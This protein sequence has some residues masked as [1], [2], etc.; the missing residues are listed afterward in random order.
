M[1]TC[2]TIVLLAVTP[3]PAALI[4]I[5]VDPATA[6]PAAVSVSVADPLSPLSVSGFLLHAAVTP[7]GNPLTLSVTAPMYVA[8]PVI[9]TAS[10]ADEPLAAE[11]ELVAVANVSTGGESVTTSVTLLLAA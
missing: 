1:T 3:S 6:V 5:V 11:T 2:T 10:V 9:V 8:L 7:A 4:V